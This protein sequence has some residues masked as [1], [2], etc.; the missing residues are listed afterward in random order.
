MAPGAWWCWPICTPCS[1]AGYL[2]TDIFLILSGFVLGRAYGGQILAG[3]VTLFGFLKKRLTRLWPAQLIVLAVMGLIVLAAEMAGDQPIAR[4]LHPAGIADAG[5]HGP[6]TGRRRRRRL[7]PPELVAVGPA[8]LLR[9]LPL[10]WRWV[11][12]LTSPRCWRWA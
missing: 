9:R 1:G 11:G 3:R 8:G 2:A 4:Q 12:R 5:L 10:L 6:G 7:E